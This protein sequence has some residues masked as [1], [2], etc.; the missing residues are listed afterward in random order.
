M[1]EAEI[2]PYIQVLD[3]F[4]FFEAVALKPVELGQHIQPDIGK[5]VN[6]QYISLTNFRPC[7]I[8]DF[9]GA[10]QQYKIDSAGLKNSLYCAE[11]PKAL[12]IKSNK[13]TNPDDYSD[14]AMA[15]FECTGKNCVTDP[16]KLQ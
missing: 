8:D 10:E 4:N 15:L 16:V 11:D 14:F 6:G 3:T 2:L 12:K 7:N 1:E 5:I 9:I 13:Q